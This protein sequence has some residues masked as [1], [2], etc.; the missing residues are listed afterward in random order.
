VCEWGKSVEVLVKITPH[1]S[2][3]GREKWRYMGIDS[4]IADIVQGLQRAGIDMEASCCGH[5]K[6][7]GYIV[8]ADGRTLALGRKES[9]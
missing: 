8:L 9:R 2:S 4:C 7:D 5:G 3:T 1:L 6:E